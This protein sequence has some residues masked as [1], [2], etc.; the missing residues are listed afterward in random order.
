M[1]LVA[2]CDSFCRL[3]QAGQ[4]ITFIE[5]GRRDARVERHDQVVAPPRTGPISNAPSFDIATLASCVD[6]PTLYR[7]RTAE[8]EIDPGSD[9]ARFQLDA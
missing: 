9:F 8:L 4:I 7:E 1:F 6:H 2:E 3:G 5:S